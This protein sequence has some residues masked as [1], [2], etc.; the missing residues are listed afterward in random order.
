M[1]TPSPQQRCWIRN[2]SFKE[3]RAAE[4]VP[5]FPAAALRPAALPLLHAAPRK[6]YRAR[7][8]AV[9]STTT[10]AIG[11]D[12]VA[13]RKL[14][15]PHEVAEYWAGLEGVERL[16]RVGG[17]ATSFVMDLG[18]ASCFACGWWKEGESHAEDV[19]EAW[20]PSRTGLERCHLVPHDKGGTGEPGNLILLCPACHLGAP[21]CLH[22][23]VMLRWAVGYESWF[24]PLL[25]RA[26]REARRACLDPPTRAGTTSFPR[27][28]IRWRRSDQLAWPLEAGCGLR[29]RRPASRRAAFIAEA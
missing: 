23:D 7:R 28:S 29:D 2:S 17:D 1:E 14:A 12:P 21:D 5:V 16:C 27:R 9:L 3:L 11:G 8:G 26:G 15:R 10:A 13:S 24:A 19:E 20:S 18:E 6:P 4:C 22:P 25:A